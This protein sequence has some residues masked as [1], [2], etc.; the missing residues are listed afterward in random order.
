MIDPEQVVEARRAAKAARRPQQ[1][2]QGPSDGRRWLGLARGD[3]WRVEAIAA[4]EGVAVAV[5]DLAIR[6]EL[7]LEADDLL[8]RVSSKSRES[9]SS[10]P[11]TDRQAAGCPRPGAFV[12]PA[13]TQ[14]AAAPG[15]RVAGRVLPNAENP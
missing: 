6:R 1:P 11:P 9:D 2:A 10:L 7:A 8:A 12:L 5:V 14:S 4:H 13:A 3:G 15:R